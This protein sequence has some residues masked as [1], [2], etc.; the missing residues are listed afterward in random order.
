MMTRDM[1]RVNSSGCGTELTA[2]VARGPAKC[3]EGGGSKLEIRR[4]QGS[5]IRKMTCSSAYHENGSG[6]GQ[7]SCGDHPRSRA[8]L[9]PPW[10]QAHSAWMLR[11]SASG[12]FA[13]RR[14]RSSAIVGVGAGI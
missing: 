12:A 2:P 8:P 11:T 3:R 1:A 14:T 6:A 9:M 13:S 4:A 10:R 5:F 7:M